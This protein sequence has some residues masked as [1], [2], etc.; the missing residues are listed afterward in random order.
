MPAGWPAAGWPPRAAPWQTAAMPVRCKPSWPSSACSGQELGARATTRKALMPPL[1]ASTPTA[2]LPH[3][4]SASSSPSRCQQKWGDGDNHSI[5]TWSPLTPGSTHSLPRESQVLLLPPPPVSLSLVP[6][7]MLPLWVWL[8]LCWLQCSKVGTAPP[9]GSPSCLPDRSKQQG[10]GR[11]VRHPLTGVALAAHPTDPG[12][13]PERSPALTDGGPAA[14]HPSLAVAARLRHLL[15]HCQVRSPALPT[16][17]V[18]AL[19]CLR[20]PILSPL[21]RQP[22]AKRWAGGGS[23]QEGARQAPMPALPPTTPSLGPAGL[24]CKTGLMKTSPQS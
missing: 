22:P 17:R 18:S 15:L 23:G 1:R 10:G 24:G 12:S 11:R 6:I 20:T 5:F 9:R 2:L 13:P 8:N 3:A 21:G 16:E 4:S 19:T 14:L 7:R